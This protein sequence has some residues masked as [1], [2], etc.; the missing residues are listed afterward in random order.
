MTTTSLTCAAA[1]ANSAADGPEFGAEYSDPV[2]GP[3]FRAGVILVVRRRDGRVLAFE[4]SDVCGA[5]Q[6]PQG[7]IDIDETPEQAAWRELAEETGLGPE[8][9]RGAGSSSRWTVYELPEEHRRPG[10]IG[11]AHRWFYFDVVDDLIEPTPD[12]VEFAD[13]AWMTPEHLIDVVAPFRRA[14]Y[15]EMLRG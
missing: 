15:E 1:S 11:Q 12:G 10:R 13:W 7:G 2:A 8:A 3:H 6:L 14:G 5:W 9:V 4:R